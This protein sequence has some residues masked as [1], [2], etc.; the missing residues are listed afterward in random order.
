MTTQKKIKNVW[1][2]AGTKGGVGKTIA[3][4][5]FTNV[6]DDL[7]RNPVLVDCDNENATF[8]RFM[9]KRTKN[10]DPNKEF[11]MDEIISIIENGKSNDYVMDLRAGSGTLTL[12][13]LEGVPFDFLQKEGIVFNLLCCVTSD[14][15]SVQTYLN[16]AE[17]VEHKMN[18]VLVFNEKDGTDFEYYEEH[19]K[20]F[21]TL[22]KPKKIIIPKLSDIYNILLNKGAV[23]LVDWLKGEVEINDKAFRGIMPKTRLKRYYQN[24]A[25]QI[26]KVVENGK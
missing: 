24:I 8:S 6:L 10:I 18:Y 17:K 7:E 1:L 13:W 23:M 2:T 26:K 25:D 11:A 3:A 4:I 5:Y 15:D 12:K 20:K 19:A 9:R 14:P 21:E 16:W 22:L